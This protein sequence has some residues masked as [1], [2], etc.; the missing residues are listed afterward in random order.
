MAINIKDEVTDRLARELARETGETITVA[1]QIALRE[2][3]TRVRAARPSAR[4]SD[5]LRRLIDRGRVRRV[6][7]RRSADEIVGYDD[8]GLPR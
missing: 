1:T 7:D 4:R 5:E 8:L 6:L 2:R 3:L